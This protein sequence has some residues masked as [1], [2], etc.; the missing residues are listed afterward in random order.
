MLGRWTVSLAALAAASLTV[1]PAAA[2][3]DFD[4][5]QDFDFAQRGFVATR[6]DP[7]I[8]AADGHVVWDLTAYDFLKG[9]APATANASLWRQGQL[10]S[11]A[12][13]FKVT[14]GV[15]QVRGF[16]IANATFIQGKT[17]WIVIDTLT[18]AEA[19]KADYD[20]VSEKLGK[21]PVAPSRGCSS[22]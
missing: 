14:D 19:A 7:K 8:V 18:S 4:N 2:D 1:G 10:L 16:D 11:K 9:P 3:P 13:L 15:W 12:G 17:G 20:L 21:R 6:A 22:R 5:R